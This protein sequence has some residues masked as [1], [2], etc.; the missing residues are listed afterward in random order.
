MDYPPRIWSGFLVTFLIGWP[1]GFKSLAE[2]LKGY[3]R[4][5]RKGA[6]FSSLAPTYGMMPR[7]SRFLVYNRRRR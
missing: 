5:R 1:E 7:R 4:L 3:K 6:A 2:D